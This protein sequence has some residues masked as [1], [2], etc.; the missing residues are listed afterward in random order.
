MGARPQTR[1]AAKVL[2]LEARNPRW[3]W[4]SVCLLLVFCLIR[5][6]WVTRGLNSPAIM[7]TFR[8]AG[9]VQGIIDGNWFG[10]PT[11]GGAWRYYPPLT[12]AFFA[13]VAAATGIEPLRLLTMSAPLLNLIVPTGFFLMTRHLI[14]AIAAV[15]GTALLVFFNDLVL[16]S[17]ISAAYH[18]WSSVPLLAL[19]GFFFS[20]W[21]IHARIRSESLRDAVLIGSAIG[22][23]FLAHTVPALILAVILPV[24]VFTTR[25]INARTLGWIAIIAVT[26]LAWSLPLLLPLLV[27][28]RLHILNPGPGAL[29][30][31]LFAAWP[32]SRGMLLT[33]LP[34]LLALPVI[35]VLRTEGSISRAAGA[36]LTVW[37]IVPIVFLTR[38][39]ACGAASQAAVCTVFVLAVHHWF[40]YLQAALTC[41]AGFAAWLCMIRLRGTTRRPKSWHSAG[42]IL[43]VLCG[44][45][46]LW[47]RPFDDSMRQ[48]ALDL[49][50]TFDW[51]AYSWVTR[52]TGPQDLFV[53]ELPDTSL[54]P[55]SLAVMAAGRRSVALPETYSNPYVEWQSRNRLNSEYLAAAQ[56]PAGRA[57][58]ALC[59]LLEET[60]Q[61]ANAY[62]ILPNEEAVASTALR[63][64]SVG[65]TNTIYRVTAAACIPRENAA[66]K[67]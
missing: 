13:A 63:R 32:P 41:L 6:L 49:G 22:L 34:G 52:H 48:R 8:D 65:E 62:V 46:A 16:P 40:I 9:F 29:V 43:G 33:I 56:A 31:P 28:Y 7:D 2:K 35:A 17:W 60:T 4:Y 67:L 36:I 27:S 14:G 53:T 21:L 55:A 42:L 24:A 3:T 45:A 20:V 66:A 59:N 1:A 10:D 15:A 50:A 38:H 5:G 11:I 44:V 19:G 51:G 30:D 37:L 58:A 25:E 47:P 64:D 61:G 23:T 57:S 18:P 39:Y 12:H 54:N 26:A